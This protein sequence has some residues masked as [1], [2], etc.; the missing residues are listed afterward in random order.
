MDTWRPANEIQVDLDW[1]RQRIAELEKENEEAHGKLETANRRIAEL[2][3]ENQRL[4]RQIVCG[5]K[6]L[7]HQPPARSTPRLIH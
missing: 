6:D 4:R 5:E 7:D 2:E 1:S 3:A